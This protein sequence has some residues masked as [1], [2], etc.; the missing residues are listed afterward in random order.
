MTVGRGFTYV[1]G[2]LI[3]GVTGYLVIRFMVNFVNQIKLRYFAFY[4]FA[5]GIIALAVNYI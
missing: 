2:M 4:C 1:L 3:A 5:A